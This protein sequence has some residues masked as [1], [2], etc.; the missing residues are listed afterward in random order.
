MIE[1]SNYLTVFAGGKLISSPTMIKHTEENIGV[2]INIRFSIFLFTLPL[3]GFGQKIINE[4]TLIRLL[5]FFRIRLIN[6]VFLPRLFLI[7]RHDNNAF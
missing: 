6:L 7:G 3:F 5:A 2:I 1:K 4:N